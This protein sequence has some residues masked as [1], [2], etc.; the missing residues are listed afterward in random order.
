LET[1]LVCAAVVALAE[2]GDKTQLLAMVLAARF[3]KPVPIIAGIFI[4]TI[5]NHVLAALGGY[6]LAS[7]FTGRVFQIAIALSFLTMAFWILIPDKVDDAHAKPATRMGAFIATSV[8]FFLAE[9]GDKTQI[10]TIA[11][12]AQFHNIFV[13]AAGTTTGMMIANVPAVLLAGTVLRRIPMRYIRICATVI[14]VSLGLWD[15]FKI[16][17]GG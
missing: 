17:R 10:A 2:V 3:N 6:Y 4:A 12:A 11:L 8:A 15:L 14:F 5:A 13:V 9:I 7:F 16:F 1:F